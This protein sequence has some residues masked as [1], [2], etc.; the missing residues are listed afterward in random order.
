MPGRGLQGRIVAWPFV[1]ILAAYCLFWGGAW[2]ATYYTNLRIWALIPAFA[3]VGVWIVIAT[4][5]PVWR[6]STILAPA[7]A[8]AFA[9]FAICSVTSRFPRFSVEYLALAVLLAAL[10]LILQ[11]LMAS[12]FFRPRMVSFAAIAGMVI[13]IAYLLIVVPHWITWWGLIGRVAAPPLR[14][15]FEGLTFGNPSAVM[16]ASVLL[17]A[18]VVAHLAGGERTSRIGALG[19]IAL[20]AVVT[21][22]SGSRAGWLAIGIT[23]IVVGVLWLAPTEHRA[24]L[25]GLVRSRSAQM[26]A[27]AV[28]V[29][30]AVGAFAVGPG[31]LLRASAG[32][33]AVRTDFYAESVRMF[34]SSPLVG[35]GP[36]TWVVER[37]AFTPPSE[38]DY[39]VPHAH[40]IY[41]QTL[42]E[43]GLVGLLA[44]VVVVFALGRLLLGALRDPDP[45]RRRMGWATLFA[46]V[47]FGAHQLLD[48]Y[49][50]APAILFAFA[51][52]VAWL[53]ATAPEGPRLSVPRLRWAWA[54]PRTIGVLAG[55]AG[56]VAIGSSAAFLAWSENGAMLMSHAR[57]LLNDRKPAEAI[58]P[59]IEAIRID[60][61][62][63]PY[64]LALGLA[65][66]DTGDLAGAEG[67]LSMAATMD[68]VPEA[69]L[70]LAAVRARLGETDAAREALSQ[71][72]RLGDQQA[73]VALGAGVVQLQIGEIDDAVDSFADAL[74]I[75]PTLAGDSWWTSD[76]ARAA[77]WPAAYRAAFD[78]GPTTA[79]FAMA[80]EADD[81]TGAASAM[82]A[83]NDP[84]EAIT[85]GIVV[86]AWGGDAGALAQLEARARERPLDYPVVNWCALLLRRSGADDEAAD[87]ATWA[88][89][90]RP[91]SSVRGHEVRV[92]TG[93]KADFIAGINTQFYG[94]Y[95][96]RRP[97]PNH[98]LVDWLPE[99]EYR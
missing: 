18:P 83:M 95:T 75:T 11:R 39:Y 17:A 71:A 91:Y 19:V 35:T 68:S 67:H 5:S 73:G 31:L 90:V 93:S 88:E 9:A 81:A 41:L 13:G 29:L 42:A 63:P 28:L 60:P 50:N 20:A 74:L 55:A 47:Y 94:H 72:L 57:D 46:T 78:R 16:T 32:G 79:Q 30:A 40:N 86:K 54:R 66:A 58:A 97:L 22:L 64:H 96:Y 65:L 49:A 61:A 70:D 59:L 76:H 85:S 56:I 7:F 98:Q 1:A 4:R 15:F 52:P 37:I 99:L 6:P 14:P 89:T 62:M 82:A 53:D 69:W 10:Y 77:V 26:L 84:N 80:L 24:S 45:G 34:Q 43:F 44:G 3:V 48:S 33:E 25:V 51:I 92:A 38:T 21:I 87:Y 8:A 12:D 2:P 23:V 36:G 27:L